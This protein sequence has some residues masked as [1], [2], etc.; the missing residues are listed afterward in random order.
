MYKGYSAQHCLLAMTEKMK[1]ARDSNKVCAVVLTDLSKAFDC[2]LH[3]LLIAKLHAFSFD[4]Q[5][6]KV[7]HAYLNDRSQVTKVSSFYSEIPQ[8][9]HGVRQSSILGP[10]LFNINLIDLFIAGHY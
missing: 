9:I 10:P 7:I 1:D 6:L 8:I 3:D 5:S 2:L 4:L